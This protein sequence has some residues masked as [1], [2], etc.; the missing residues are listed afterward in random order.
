MFD[1]LVKRKKMD[2][3]KWKCTIIIWKIKIKY[4]FNSLKVGK[5]T[6][7][8][9]FSKSLKICNIIKNLH[10]YILNKKKLQKQGFANHLRILKL[11]LKYLIHITK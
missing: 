8:L 1:Q 2:E 9:I 3:I 5:T 10:E 6:I 4:I 7:N 11:T